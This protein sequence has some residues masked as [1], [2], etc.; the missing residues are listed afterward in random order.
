M[1]AYSD[2][3]Q[4]DEPSDVQRVSGLQDSFPL[5]KRKDPHIPLPQGRPFPE[6]GPCH[7][8]PVRARMVLVHSGSLLSPL[9]SPGLTQSAWRATVPLFSLFL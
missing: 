6:Y 9:A 5:K 1:E 7:Q 8:Q 3:R 2:L 4:G